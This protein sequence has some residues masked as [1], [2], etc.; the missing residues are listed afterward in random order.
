MRYAVYLSDLREPHDVLVKRVPTLAR[1]RRIA[2]EWN[3][4]VIDRHGP[5]LPDGSAS[6]LYYADVGDYDEPAEETPEEE[7]AA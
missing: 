6:P 4:E 5:V 3:R 7:V 2:A 1:A